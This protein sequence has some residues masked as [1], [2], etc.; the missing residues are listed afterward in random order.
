[1]GT[2]QRARL[3]VPAAFLRAL[4]HLHVRT[5]L[6]ELPSTRSSY[7]IDAIPLALGPGPSNLNAA[8]QRRPQ[9]R[10]PRR[11]QSGLTG[12]GRG[13]RSHRERP[14]PLQFAFWLELEIRG[15]ASKQ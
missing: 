15:A 5:N 9:R 3:D 2:G 14:A 10:C 11:A 13:V 8:G 4:A 12:T 7:P 6:C 1:M